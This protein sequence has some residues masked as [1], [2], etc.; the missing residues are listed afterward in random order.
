MPDF[1][2]ETFISNIGGFVG[3]FLGY[4]M[5][6]FPQLLGNA[7]AWAMSWLSIVRTYCQN[8]T[9]T[10]QVISQDESDPDKQSHDSQQTLGKSIDKTN[11]RKECFLASTSSSGVTSTLQMGEDWRH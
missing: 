2:L 9:G 5:M 8:R 3:I 6:Q 1:D 10:N 11:D 7:I 4:S